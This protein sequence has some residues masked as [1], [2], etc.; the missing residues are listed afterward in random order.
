MTGTWCR[1]VHD[2]SKPDGLEEGKEALRA[3]IEDLAGADRG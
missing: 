2:L 1:L 3:L